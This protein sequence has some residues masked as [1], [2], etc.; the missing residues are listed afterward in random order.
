MALFAPFETVPLSSWSGWALGLALLY[1]GSRMVYNVY[2]H[3]LRHYPGPKLWA[4][5]IL[6]YTYNWLARSTYS[7]ISRLHA[8]YG[9]VVRVAPNRLSYIHPDAWNDIRGHRKM[10][11]GE[12][13]KDPDFYST[14]IHNLLGAN[15]SDHARF[16][17]ALAHGFSARSMQLQQPLIMQYMDLLLSRLNDKVAPTSKGGNPSPAVVDLAAYFNYTTFDV[18]GDL[19]FGS[20]FGCLET[21][22]LHPW[23]KVIFDTTPNVHIIIALR[24][25]VPFV[26]TALRTLAPN[27]LGKTMADQIAFAGKRV[28][29]RLSSHTSRPDYIDAMIA[30]Q[31]DA[32]KEIEYFEIV[33]NARLLVFAGSETT[34]TALSGA[35]WLLAMHPE[36]QK[37]LAQEVRSEFKSGDEIDM[38]SVQKLKYMLAVLDESLRL[39][40]AVP[41]SLPRIC[42]KGG[43]TIC[44]K[45]VPEGAAM[46]IWPM[47]VFHSSRNFTDPKKFIPERWLDGPESERFAKD[48]VQAFQPFSVGP[49]NC[50][51]RNLAYTE[52]RLIMAKLMWNFD[53]SP[54]DEEARSWMDRCIPFHLWHRPPLNIK[55]TPVAR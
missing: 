7:S 4:A 53:L 39:L 5:S 54:A 12:H 40:P 46:E 1:A 51:G 18:I 30:G 52:M 15:R 36:V 31:G 42:Q 45:Y 29:K 28:D 21:E 11:E 9:D 23:V 8:R 34:A 19:S 35:A 3:P 17:R 22:E 13:T 26:I 14:A 43:D 25:V 50:I 37:K 41:A 27:V 24:R 38:H 33:E 2:F 6:P 16:R 44:G 20:P 10:G 49:R 48:R 55:L 32:D 47:V